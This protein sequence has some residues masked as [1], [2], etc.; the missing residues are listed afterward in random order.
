MAGVIDTNLLLYAANRNAEE[1]PAAVAFLGAAMGGTEPWFLTEGI[2]YEFMRVSTH[3]KVFERPLTWK[4]GFRFIR[5][6]LMSRRF[7]MLTAGENHWT[8]LERVLADLHRPS[9]NLF[10]DIRTVVLMRERGVRE[11]YTTD[12]DFLQFRDIRVI[13]PLQ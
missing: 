2:L 9:G 1:H 5:P 13:N 12:T 6:L 4:E 3:P 10:F 7:D 11:I 8:I